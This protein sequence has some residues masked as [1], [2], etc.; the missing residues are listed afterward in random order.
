MNNDIATLARKFLRNGLLPSDLQA[1]YTY[2]K[3]TS[4]AFV[5]TA[6]SFIVGY[7]VSADSAALR[8]LHVIKTQLNIIKNEQDKRAALV[9]SR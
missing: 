2:S 6:A 3:I 7:S 9:Y 1:I 4:M 8:D 5:I